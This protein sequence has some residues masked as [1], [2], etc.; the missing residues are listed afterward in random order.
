MAP[1]GL[2]HSNGLSL[3]AAPGRPKQPWWLWV[4]SASVFCVTFIA[5]G[6]IAL[7]LRVPALPNCPAIFWPI[8]SAS[9]RLYCAEVAA[10]KRTVRDLLEAITLVE[11]LPLDHE[12]RPQANRYLATWVEEILRLADG[13]V[14]AGNLEEALKIARKIPVGV[15]S[16]PQVARR[17]ADWQRAWREAEGIYN[18]VLRSIDQRQWDGAVGN[19]NRLV[20]GP[21][22]Y[23]ATVKHDELRVL[24]AETR[25]DDGRIRRAQGLAKQGRPADF[26]QAF[27]VLRE[28]EPRRRLYALAQQ[29]IAELTDQALAFAQQAIDR[30]NGEAALRWA[31]LLP[32]RESL[33]AQAE[34][35]RNLAAAE[36]A[37]K[38]GTAADLEAAI[39][40]ASKIPQG[41]PLYDRAQGKIAQW[42]RD[43]K[44]AAI[45]D[46]ARELARSGSLADLTNAIAQ[47]QDISDS[48]SIAAV[49]RREITNWSRQIQELRDRPVLDRAEELAGQGRWGEAIAEAQKIEPESPLADSARRQITTWRDRADRA[50][51]EPILQ[52]AEQLARSG[53]LSG[54]I[55]TANRIASGRS[56][57]QRAQ[58][59]IARWQ[60]QLQSQGLLAEAQQLAAS[61][62]P[63]GLISAIATASRVDRT[64]PSRN[65]ADGDIGRWS[66]QLL[67]LAQ[68]QAA[69]G[70]LPGAIALAQ[71]IPR[72]ATTYD[73]AQ[74]QITTWQRW[75]MPAASPT[76]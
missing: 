11:A 63:D 68:Q 51:D 54:A 60:G 12:L 50:Q 47:A 35:L 49:S 42:Q 70:D 8:A 62:T 34:D 69:N 26:E 44:D 72:A 24:I 1:R 66:Q 17:M 21:L 31:D 23:W 46:R 40:E 20:R 55:D 67:A 16:Y 64:S 14:Q 30:G 73:A 41:R 65:Q 36:S 56:L 18:A 27:E 7:L 52:Q 6:A 10:N 29:T 37:A 53:D 33:R 48:S 5:L 22:R 76:P 32:D 3:P 74:V 39:A 38:G 4:G 43:G 9:V 61:N 59:A 71:R 58:Q 2:Q 15:P 57:Y 45:L 13:A 19:A 75:L 25:Q 28:I